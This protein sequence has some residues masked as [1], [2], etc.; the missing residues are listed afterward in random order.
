MNFDLCK[1]KYKSDRQSIKKAS[2]TQDPLCL[3]E[4]SDSCSQAWLKN[5]GDRQTHTHTHTQ[6]DG[7]DNMIVAPLGKGQL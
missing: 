5:V 4:V 6:T 1:E 3:C 2:G 7:T